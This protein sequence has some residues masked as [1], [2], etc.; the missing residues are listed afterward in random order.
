MDLSGLDLQNVDLQYAN[1]YN[2]K[3]VNTNLSSANLYNSIV[4]VAE[5]RKANINEIKIEHEKF[6][7]IWNKIQKRKKYDYRKL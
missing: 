2:C 5:L 1:L 7:Q 4:D 3:L 6:M